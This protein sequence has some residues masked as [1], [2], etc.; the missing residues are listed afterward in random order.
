[1]GFLKLRVVLLLLISVTFL[2]ANKNCKRSITWGDPNK[3]F[4]SKWEDEHKDVN[5]NTYCGE[6]HDDARSSKKA[7]NIHDSH[8]IAWEREHGKFSQ[9]KYG[10]QQQNVCSLC[11]TDSSC[12]SCHMQE[13]PQNHTMFWKQ[14]GH[15][16]AVGLDRN[17][18]STCHYSADFCE[19]CHSETEPR[20]HNAL[21]GSRQNNHCLSCHVPV[22][23]SGAQKCAVCHQS[24]PS[25]SSAPAQPNNAIHVSGVN[26]RTCHNPVPH[27]DNGDSCETCHQ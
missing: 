24:T 4:V 11:H 5:S 7:P 21:W 17:K 12:T 6:C 20:D 25:H 14:R 8:G 22:S 19:R 1:M 16:L 18:C 15:G 2:M 26:C 13:P 23:S 9:A 27:A 3:N 10:F